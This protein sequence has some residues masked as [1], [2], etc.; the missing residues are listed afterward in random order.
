V[1]VVPLSRNELLALPPVITLPVLGR[2]LG[3]SEPTIRERVRRGE[4]E[5]LGI[6]AVKLGQQWRI[7]TEDVLH[8]LG[9]TRE[10]SLD[11]AEGMAPCAI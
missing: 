6:R 5:P 3:V 9:V 7:V 11:I 8:A 1:T 4:L 2:A 10:M